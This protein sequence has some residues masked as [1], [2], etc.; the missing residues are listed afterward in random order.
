MGEGVG[1][2]DGLTTEN[3]EN[4]ER[5]AIPNDPSV[6]W[7]LTLCN[8]VNSVVNAGRRANHRKHREHGE[9]RMGGKAMDVKQKVLHFHLIHLQSSSSF[10]L[11]LCNSVV[12]SGRWANHRGHR[13]HGEI[14]NSQLL[15]LGGWE[16][17]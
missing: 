11:S 10:Y 13:E 12:N 2:G 8:S 17:P 4:P 15:G 3:T 9:M 6:V 7:F 14:S 16:T 1:S 5:S